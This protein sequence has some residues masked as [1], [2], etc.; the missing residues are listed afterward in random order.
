LW[1]LSANQSI[2]LGYPGSVLGAS[3]SPDGQR[4]LTTS[5]DGTARLW[6][7]SGRQL[8]ELT[9]QG[10]VLSA[11]FSPDGRH[12]ILTASNERIARLWQIEGL[13]QLMIRGCKWLKYY[14]STHPKDRE[15]LKVCCDKSDLTTTLLSKENKGP[16]KVR[17]VG[18][19]S[20]VFL[21]ALF[22]PDLVLGPSL[23]MAALSFEAPALFIKAA[24][25]DSNT[26]GD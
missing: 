22:R 17:N 1:D 12:I 13:S 21:K 23:E 7:L 20:S 24:A 10:T 8:A 9:G 3:F 2:E 16:K 4:I 14:F 11:S 19:E 18:D 15:T 25:S 26:T 5:Q 6:D